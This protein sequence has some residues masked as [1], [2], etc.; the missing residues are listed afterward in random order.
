MID[1]VVRG[2]RLADDSQGLTDLLVDDGRFVPVN[3]A[4]YSAQSAAVYGMRA[5]RHRWPTPR[6]RW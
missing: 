3:A 6:A 5:P 2:V 4:G 1:L